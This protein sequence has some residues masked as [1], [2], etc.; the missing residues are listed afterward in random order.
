M[1][2]GKTGAVVACLLLVLRR[3]NVMGNEALLRKMYS[4]SEKYNSRFRSKTYMEAVKE[5]CDDYKY[6]FTEML[7]E[8]DGVAAD[9]GDTDSGEVPACVLDRIDG[10]AAEFVAESEAII[11]TGGKQPGS[12]VMLGYNM[13]AYCLNNPVMYF[14]VMGACAHQIIGDCDTCRILILSGLYEETDTEEIVIPSEEDDPFLAS[15]ALDIGLEITEHSLSKILLGSVR[16][17]NIG[18]GT[19]NKIINGQIN[20]LSGICKAISISSAVLF[21]GIDVAIGIDY[22]LQNNASAGKIVYDI[23]VDVAVSGGMSVASF[24]AGAAIG[25]ACCPIVGTIVGVGISVV[26]Y[27]IFDEWGLRNSIKDCVQ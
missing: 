19:Y 11:K 10:L 16:P 8:I 3:I 2:G 24:A 26:G 9:C 7:G 1:P 5:F 20:Q 17:A 22:N 12:R 15:L 23:G 4:E 6:M 21:T 14:D 13:Y 25:T 18:A 27:L